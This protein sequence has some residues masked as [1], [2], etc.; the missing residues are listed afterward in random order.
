MESLKFHRD[1][2]D[3]SGMA[4][5]LSILAIEA[6]WSGDFSSALPWLEEAETL[7]RELGDQAGEADTL[8][9]LGMLAYWQSDYR[10]ACFHYQ[11]AMAMYEKL[12]G[13]VAI[14]GT[15]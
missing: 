5:C 12:G 15:H 3:L 9:N 8:L 7:Y 10:Q 1:L 11:Q 4:N 13:F 14:L 6:I 2:G